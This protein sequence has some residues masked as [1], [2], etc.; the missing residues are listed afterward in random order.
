MLHTLM[1]F[2]METNSITGL[3]YQCTWFVGRHFD[4]DQ[5]GVVSSPKLLSHW[6]LWSVKQR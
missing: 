3:D 5:K 6:S 2:S 1:C 4:Q